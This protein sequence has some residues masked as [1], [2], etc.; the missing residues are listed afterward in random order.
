MSD[1]EADVLLWS[2]HQAELLRRLAAGER[3]N[4]QVDWEN[5]IEEVESVGS[6]QLHAVQ[7]LLRQALIHLLKARAWPLCRD[8][9]TWRADVVRFRADV[10][11]RFAPSMR[12]R[13]D[14]AR[15]YRQALRAL[16]ETMDGQPPQPVP[17]SCPLTLEE[18]LAE[19]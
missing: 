5:V 3:V 15:I 9:A 2:E 17:E 11:D 18:L 1:Y 13:I 7:S 4:D 16:P 12:Q 14:I 10:A 8:A 19:D 6:E